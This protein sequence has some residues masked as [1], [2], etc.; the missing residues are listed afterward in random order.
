MGLKKIDYTDILVGIRKIIRVVNIEN[1][2]IEK[3]Y[4][5]SIPQLLCMNFLNKQK[6]H[7]SNSSS[8]KQYLNLNA[9]TVTGIVD[10]LE[11]KGY[12]AKLP[13]IGDRRVSRITLTKKGADLVQQFPPLMHE[14]LA[15]KLQELPLNKLNEIQT[16]ISFLTKIMGAENIDASPVITIEDPI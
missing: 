5:V 15:E 2:Q 11:K 10:R 1:K 8:I 7:T 16:T 12:I 13:K 3:Q 14:R 4:G 9:S 6:D